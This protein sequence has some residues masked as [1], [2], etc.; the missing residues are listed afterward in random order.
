MVAVLDSGIDIFSDEFRDAEGN[1]RIAALW[2]QTLENGLP[3]EGFVTG[4]Y[5][6]KE[7]INILKE[8]TYFFL[9]CYNTPSILE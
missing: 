1:T 9:K 7:E 8:K 2:D 6:S 3:P 5:F 4:R